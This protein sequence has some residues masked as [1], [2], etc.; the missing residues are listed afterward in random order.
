[1]KFNELMRH[2]TVAFQITGQLVHLCTF[3]AAEIAVL[4]FP[5]VNSSVWVWNGET[6]TPKCITA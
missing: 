2:R 4:L 6:E 3:K 5:P 1:M